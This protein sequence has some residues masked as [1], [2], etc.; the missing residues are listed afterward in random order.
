[1]SE[2]RNCFRWQIDRQAK[3]KL[4]GAECFS[5]CHIKDINLKGIQ[6][7]SRKKL[8]RDTFIK[9]SLCLDENCAINIEAWVVWH[10]II[11][12]FNLYGLYFS[13]IHDS[14]KEKIYQFIFRNFPEQVSR[15][16][17]QGLTEE[18]GGEIMQKVRPE[19]KRIFARFSANF[20]LRFLNLR[21]GKEGEASTQDISAKGIGFVTR[22][23]LQP[24]TLLEM[25]LQVPDKGEPFYTRGNVIWSKMAESDNYR[26]GV[27]LEKANLMGM[28][29]VLRTI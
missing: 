17:W 10:K 7:S 24:D 6:V 29:R 16:W 2:R 9:L 22:E 28:S 18:K 13:R 8:P 4:E 12:G 11:D 27:N 5:D 25:W 15:C 19:D 20:P 23:Q 1:M 21:S 26:V 14:N 3:V